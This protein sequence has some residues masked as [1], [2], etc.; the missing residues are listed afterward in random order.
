MSFSDVIRQK[1]FRP[2]PLFLTNSIAPTLYNDYEKG[3]KMYYELY[4]DSLFLV[5]FCMNL[6]LLLLVNERT[7]RTATGLR[8][9][10]GA[11]AG[12][13]LFLFPF[14]LNGPAGLKAAI[15][16]VSGICGMLF[17]AFRVRSLRAFFSLSEKL[18]GYSFLMGGALL[19]VLRCVN[20]LFP[21]LQ[22][23]LRG[24]FGVMGMGAALFL[25]FF[26]RRGR[27]NEEIC[28]ATLVRGERREQ[29]AAL[30]DSGNLLTEPV[31]GKP[32]CVLD[33]EVFERFW[34]GE[35]VYYR[36]IPYHS[37]GKAAGILKGYLLPELRL[38]LD[39][40]EKICRD[41]YIAVSDEPV[42]GGEQRQEEGVRLIVNPRLLA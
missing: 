17:G 36:A 22:S 29:V 34:E 31:S 6:F 19:F 14:F 3:D 15:G 1:I 13:V 26:Y 21:G 40:V 7:H 38:E 20:R 12:A 18:I 24:I 27:Q 11:A 25:V 33:R 9:I 41:V 30:L 35:A 32:V 37:V 42:N 16:A 2:S 4:V 8:L 5:N 10:L 28:A 23:F 39:G